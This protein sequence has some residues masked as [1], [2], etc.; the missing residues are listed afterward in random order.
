[1]INKPLVSVI[2]ACYNGALYIERSLKKLLEQTYGSVE[3]IFVNDGSTDNTE[4]IVLSYKEKFEKRGY[5]IVYIKQENQGVGG[6]TNTALKYVKGEYF[7]LCDADN[8]FASD[9][10]EEM[11]S[12]FQKNPQFSIVRCNGYI[13]SEKNINEPIRTIAGGHDELFKEDLFEN[14][15]FVKNFHFGSAIFRT[16]DFDKIN[17]TRQIYPSRHGQNWQ[18][19]LPM[20]Y[21]YKAGYIDKPMCYVLYRENSIYNVVSKQDVIKQYEQKNEYCIIIKETL[22]SINMPNEERDAYIKK[23]EIIYSKQRL[24]IA[25]KNKDFFKLEEEYRFLKMNDALTR[26]DV[27]WYR[28]CKNKFY[29]L[30]FVVGGG[31]SRMLLKL[32]KSYSKNKQLLLKNKNK[33]EE[34]NK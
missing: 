27:R 18:I 21:N 22:N 10:V 4:E 6:A 23:I 3:L 30:L 26:I 19:L 31:A 16:K 25:S 8:F 15:L 14:C 34:V 9:Y 17:P 33:K 28:R 11:V 13:V 32:K 7:T 5:Q 1:M 12:F 24:M 2:T 20:F 29:N